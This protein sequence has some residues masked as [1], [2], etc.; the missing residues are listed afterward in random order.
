MLVVERPPFLQ[1]S[2]G[3]YAASAQLTVRSE[4]EAPARYRRSGANEDSSRTP[5]AATLFGVAASR[6]L[7]RGLLK[8]HNVT[9]NV[10]TVVSRD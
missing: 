8:P 1:H 3:K 2:A 4:R 5:I 10:E 7:N 6:Q 9:S